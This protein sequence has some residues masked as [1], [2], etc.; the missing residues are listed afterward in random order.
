MRTTWI[1]VG[2]GVCIIG[3]M[4]LLINL[5]SSPTPKNETPSAQPSPKVVSGR[6]PVF[7]SEFTGGKSERSRTNETSNSIPV[8]ADPSKWPDDSRPVV[9]EFYRFAKLAK[10]RNFDPRITYFTTNSNQRSISVETI[11]H[12]AE[13]EAKENRI[14]F[15]TSK[16]DSMETVSDHPEIVSTWTLDNGTWDQQELIN[17]TAALLEQF[18]F[19]NTQKGVRTGRQEV[20]I[21]EFKTLLPDGTHAVVHP[22]AT[23]IFHD[24]THDDQKRVNAEYRMRE[25]GS[26]ELVSWSAW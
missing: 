15:L 7:A 3:V 12:A 6:I 18:G 22:F 17:M 2:L 10:L 19:A 5:P 4:A 13:I 11:T 23:V 16:L 14:P 9:K 24:A 1:I 26:A 21:S 20:Q 25:D 8:Y